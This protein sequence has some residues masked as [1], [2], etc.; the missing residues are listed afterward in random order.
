VSLPTAAIVGRP[1]VGKSTLFNRLVGQRQAIVHD[2]P[3]VTRDRISAVMRRA[4]GTA[5]QL[6][7]TGGLL[8]GDDILG[9]NRQVFL[10]VEESDALLMVVDGRDGLVAADRQVWERLRRYGKPTIL[11]VNKSDTNEAREN[12]TDF[13][14]MGV[15]AQVLVSAEHARGMDDLHEALDEALPARLDE[16]VPEAPT[17]AIVGRPNVGKS[18]LVNCVVGHERV[19]VSEVA[20]TTR[21][22]IDSL[23]EWEGQPYLLIDTAGIRRRSQVSGAAEGLAV[24]MARRQ[25]DRAQVAVLVIDA[26][27]GVTSSDLAIAG[28]VREQG[29][30]AVVAINKWDLLTTE[31]DRERLEESWLRLDEILSSPPRVNLSALSG[32]G[33]Q[34]LFP[35]V[36][37]ILTLYHSELSTGELNRL[38]SQALIRHQAPSHQGR[39]WKIYYSTQVSTAPPTFMLF[40][41]RKLPR[42]STYRRYLENFLREQT[43]WYGFPIRLVVRSRTET[44]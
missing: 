19:L 43:Q 40:A 10:A 39:P 29:K 36:E 30:A 24:M 7:D 33:L 42:S 34:R 8:D 3:G 35:A 38:L 5:L 41:N 25:I 12:F 2:K 13:F 11:V 27:A 15:G 18:S 4:D 32:R 22:P 6:I 14:A 28:V 26:G 16:V 31:D 23:I 37:K 17:V 44:R 1:N 20:G 21:D 9:L